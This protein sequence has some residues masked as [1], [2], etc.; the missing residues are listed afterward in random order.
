M[1]CVAVNKEGQI[2]F[3]E[4]L[5]RTKYKYIVINIAFIAV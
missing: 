4:W 2:T 5:V 1:Y 3:E